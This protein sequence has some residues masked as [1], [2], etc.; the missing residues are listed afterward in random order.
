MDHGIRTF[1]NFRSIY[2]DRR[3][4]YEALKHMKSQE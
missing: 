3:S 2:Q 1:D 4:H